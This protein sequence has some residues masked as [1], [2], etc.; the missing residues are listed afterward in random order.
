[1]QIPSLPYR[2]EHTTVVAAGADDVWRSLGDTLDRSFSRP[3]ANR[4]A[5]LVGCADRTASGPRPLAEGST[6]P[7]FRVAAALPGRE[8]VLGGRHRFSSYALIFRLEPAGPGRS[9]LTAETRATFPGPAGGLY[10]LLVLGTGGHAV[11]VRRLLAAVR[12]RAES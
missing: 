9:R 6:I 7:G 5:R 3:G 10:R 4:Y 8:L 1:M 12:R 2:D 11:G